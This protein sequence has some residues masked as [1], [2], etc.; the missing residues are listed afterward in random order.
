MKSLSAVNK[1]V[2]QIKTNT[3]ATSPETSVKQM[4][5]SQFY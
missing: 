2:Q 5:G 3:I 1:K 4:K